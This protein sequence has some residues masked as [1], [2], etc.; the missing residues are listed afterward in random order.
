VPH[1][2]HLVLLLPPSIFSGKEIFDH[3]R[4]SATESE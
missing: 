2:Q 4:P 3:A 1:I